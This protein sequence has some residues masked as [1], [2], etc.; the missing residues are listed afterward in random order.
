METYT[1]V[2]GDMVDAICRRVYG[3][4]SEF[5]EAVLKAN[6]GLADHLVLPIGTVVNLPELQKPADL[7]TVSLWD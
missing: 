2:Q 1:S 4:E 3:D 6:S 7:Q 5:V